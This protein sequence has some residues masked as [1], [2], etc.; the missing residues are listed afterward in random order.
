MYELNYSST[1]L[2][3]FTW[4][5]RGG[6]VIS[7]PEHHLTLLPAR[8]KYSVSLLGSV[9]NRPIMQWSLSANTGIFFSSG[10]KTPDQFIILRCSLQENFQVH[11][12]IHS[13]VKDRA[14]CDIKFI[15]TGVEMRFINRIRAERRT[16]AGRICYWQIN[17]FLL[18]TLDLN[19]VME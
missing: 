9:G 16:A 14:L 1:T 6:L 7:T 10:G 4:P 13:V 5:W 18:R 2:V 8:I 19:H 17:V 3:I 11:L 15:C 12:P